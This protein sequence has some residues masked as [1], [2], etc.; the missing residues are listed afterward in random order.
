[1]KFLQRIAPL[2]LLALVATSCNRLI[3]DSGDDCPTLIRFT[4]YVQ[5]PCMETPT[6]PEGVDRMTVIVFDQGGKILGYK[7]FRE[8]VLS[9]E[10]T[11]EI[12][13]P[14]NKEK[15]YQCYF[16]AGDVE[17]DYAYIPEVSEYPTIDKAAFGLQLSTNGRIE[18]KIPHTLYHGKAEVHNSE[19]HVEAVSTV[20]YSKPR[21][22]EYT[23][24]FVIRVTG[25]K[26]S[27]PCRMEI[28]DNNALYDMRGTLFSSQKHVT[29]SAD[30]PI[31]GDRREVTLRTLRLDDAATHPEL[32]MLRSDT[33]EELLHFDLKKDL[34][35]KLPSYKP[36]CDHLF[37]IDLKFSPSMS[38]EISING[39]VVHNY[40]I[41]L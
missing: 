11:F 20:L 4:P 19:S 39:W 3:Y 36:E 27:M 41:E 26:P 24:D 40:D 34:L 28:R 31:G 5:T 30:M 38:V 18:N 10:S 7:T 17:N 21:L 23:N 1:M 16:W 15:V 9:A 13:L 6:Y 29:Y 14:N 35:A 32:V 8:V 12:T 33:G 22:V 2:L 25:L 37:T